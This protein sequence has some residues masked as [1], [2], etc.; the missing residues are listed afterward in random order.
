MV[1]D[2]LAHI[3]SLDAGW[4]L[5][6]ALGNLHWV[7]AFAAV[8]LIFFEGQKPLRAFI[9]VSFAAMFFA[10]FLPFIGWQE[11][12]GP[13]LLLYYLAELSLLKFAETIPFFA[14]RLVWVEEFA[15]FGSVILFNLLLA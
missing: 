10:A 3:A 2:I 15:F 11:F 4:L 9:H 1:W 5:D 12:A 13:F 8:S 6:F 14:K 7:F